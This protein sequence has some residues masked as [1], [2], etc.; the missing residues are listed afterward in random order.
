MIAASVIA[1]LVLGVVFLIAAAGF[2]RSRR[3]VADIERN[4]LQLRKGTRA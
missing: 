2:R 1:A 3:I 4:F